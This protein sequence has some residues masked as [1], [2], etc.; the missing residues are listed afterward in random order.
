MKNILHWFRF[1]LRALLLL[2]FFPVL[3]L[4]FCVKYMIF[5]HILIRHMT[6]CGM[7]KREAINMVKEINPIRIVKQ[8]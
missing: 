3:V 5:K 6:K 1:I 2:L 4:I 8:A 7:P